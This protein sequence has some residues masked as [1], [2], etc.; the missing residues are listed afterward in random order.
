MYDNVIQLWI[1]NLF[2]DIRIVIL[3]CWDSQLVGNDNL[4]KL[5]LSSVMKS[6]FLFLVKPNEKEE[7]SSHTTGALGLWFNQNFDLM[8]RNVY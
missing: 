8:K 7:D 6:I 5:T 3:I 2:I 4:Q 1:L